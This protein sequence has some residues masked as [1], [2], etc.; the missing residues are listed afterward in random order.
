LDESDLPE[1]IVDS[2][3]GLQRARA[4]HSCTTNVAT[5]SET[6]LVDQNSVQ[7]TRIKTNSLIKT[8]DSR[9]KIPNYDIR[10]KATARARGQQSN[11]IRNERIKTTISINVESP[12]ATRVKNPITVFGRYR[13]GESRR[14]ISGGAI[15]TVNAQIVVRTKCSVGGREQRVV[16]REA[17]NIAHSWHSCQH[18]KDY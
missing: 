3:G 4:I 10:H 9:V 17:E 18:Q 16:T 2:R 7:N 12:L 8:V 1:T 15:R 14:R 6:R 5:K 11:I 13:C